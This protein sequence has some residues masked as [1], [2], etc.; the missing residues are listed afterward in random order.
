MY[1]CNVI[2]VCWDALEY[3]KTTINSLFESTSNYNYRLTII[4]NN[5]KPNAIEY[6]KSIEPPSNVKM[7]IIYNNSNVGICKINKQIYRN[8]LRILQFTDSTSSCICMART[9]VL[10]R[11]GYFASSKFCGYGFGVYC[12][13]Y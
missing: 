8:S 9:S 13:S 12:Y 7:D 3:T 1:E 6:L 5:S 2:I 4:D 11:I 10:E